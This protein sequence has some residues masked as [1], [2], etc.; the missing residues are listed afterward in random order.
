MAAFGAQQRGDPA[1][2]L[3]APAVGGAHS[4]HQAVGVQSDHPPDEVDLLEGDRE[5]L[6]LGQT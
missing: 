4:E 2:R 5:R 1:R 6:G 3:G